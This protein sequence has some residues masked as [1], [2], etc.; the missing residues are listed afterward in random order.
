M[1]VLEN[2]SETERQILLAKITSEIESKTT[3]EKPTTQKEKKLPQSSNAANLTRLS[4]GQGLSFGFGDEIEAGIN[5]LRKYYGGQGT[6]DYQKEVSDIRKE[7]D[8]YRQTKPR[9]SI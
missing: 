6:G 7:L 5:T 8:L 2:L 9:K 1:I 3:P 4:L